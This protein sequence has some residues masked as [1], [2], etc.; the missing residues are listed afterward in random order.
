MLKKIIVNLLKKVTRALEGDKRVTVEEYSKRPATSGSDRVTFHAETVKVQN[1]DK[2]VSIMQERILEQDEINESVSDIQAQ[3]MVK[4]YKEIE[5]ILREHHVQVVQHFVMMQLIALGSYDPEKDNMEQYTMEQLIA[6]ALENNQL[7]FEKRMTEMGKAEI[8]PAQRKA[9]ENICRVHS[10]TFTGKNK[11]EASRF[12]EKYNAPKTAPKLVGN[13][14]EKQHNAIVSLCTKLNIPLVECKS[15]AEASDVIGKLTAQVNANPELNKATENQVDYVKRL[16]KSL[17]KRWTKVQDAK[18]RA[19][20]KD[21]ISSAIKALEAHVPQSTTI[22]EGQVSYISQL[23]SRLSKPYN[24]EEIKLMDKTTASSVISSLRR[25]LLLVLAKA[26]GTPITAKDVASM[27]EDAVKELVA[28]MEMEI[29]TKYYTKE[30][31]EVENS[32]PTRR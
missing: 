11:F 29:K 26:T 2:P 4:G 32:T 10:V 12:I 30:V 7:Q 28:Q 9:I 3:I 20:S 24:V 19:M 13:I 21:E 25:E 5:N 8:T 1:L 6:M 27:N 17:N 23:C 14:T 31:T 18:Y 15:I 22:T 16:L